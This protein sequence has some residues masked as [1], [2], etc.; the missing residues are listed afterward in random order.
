MFTL[1]YQVLQESYGGKKRQVDQKTILLSSVKAWL[2]N[3]GPLLIAVTQPKGPKVLSR[4]RHESG[5]RKANPL[6]SLESKEGHFS[7]GSQT[8][9]STVLMGSS[10]LE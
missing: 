10:P 9:P 3:L 6:A 2:Y 8:V 7:L 4:V 1:P 5:E